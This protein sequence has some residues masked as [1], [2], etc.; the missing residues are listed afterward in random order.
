VRAAALEVQEPG[1]EGRQA[2]AI[3]HRPILTRR[4][5]LHNVEQLV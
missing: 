3:G 5:R 2:I 4:R 1:V